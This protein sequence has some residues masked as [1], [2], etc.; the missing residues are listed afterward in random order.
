MWYKQ[1]F[2]IYQKKNQTNKKREQTVVQ[3]INKSSV[4][5]V[6]ATETCIILSCN[7][8]FIYMKKRRN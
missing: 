1:V 6:N 4:E 3:E 8:T 2:E 5:N 7:I